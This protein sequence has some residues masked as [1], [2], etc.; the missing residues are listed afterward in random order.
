MVIEM[1]SNKSGCALSGTVKDEHEFECSCEPEE[2]KSHLFLGIM[3]ALPAGLMLWAGALRVAVE[4]A[5]R[6]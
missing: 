4:I 5:H 6:L 2:E 1:A 3:I